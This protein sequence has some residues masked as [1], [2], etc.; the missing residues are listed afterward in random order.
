M[1]SKFAETDELQRAI[2]AVFEDIK[3]Q[4][5]SYAV[6]RANQTPSEAVVAMREADV[7]AHEI[8]QDEL[9]A[10]D[11]DRIKGACTELKEQMAALETEIAG[12]ST[13]INALR[14]HE[15]Q[16]IIKQKK[17]RADKAQAALEI[18]GIEERIASLDG[19][20]GQENEGKQ[21]WLD[22]QRGLDSPD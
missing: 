6:R 13:E 10:A 8:L 1:H 22:M 16:C 17:G 21:A 2:T 7:I 15:A 14:E 12:L 19:E 5:T 18:R 4:A 9:D 20:L 11:K 3:H